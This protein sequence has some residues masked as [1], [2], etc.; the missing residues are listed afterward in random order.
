MSE[1]GSDGGA[2]RAG[3]METSGAGRVGTAPGE[4]EWGCWGKWGG[5]AAENGFFCAL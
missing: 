1:L 2:E 4:G 3:P 5:K